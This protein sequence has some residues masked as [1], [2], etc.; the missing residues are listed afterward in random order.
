[1]TVN[2]YRKRI[3]IYTNASLDFGL[4]AYMSLILG[5][6]RVP[7]RTPPIPAKPENLRKAEFVAVEM[8]LY[9]LIT[10][11]TPMRHVLWRSQVPIFLA[12]PRVST[13]F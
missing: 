12:F 4:Q 1:M 6:A 7:G 11:A 9:A 2:P 10:L 13:D 5:R 8:L 3:T